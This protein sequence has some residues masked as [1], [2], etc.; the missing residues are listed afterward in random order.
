MSRRGG[1]SARGN[2]AAIEAATRQRQRAE[3]VA[4]IRIE[5]I[6]AG[7]DGVGRADGLACFVPRTAPGDVA[8]VA[9]QTHARHARGR[10]LQLL[11]ASPLRVEPTCRHYDGDRCGGCQLQHLNVDAQREARLTI[12]QDALRRIGKR[13]VPRATLVSGKEW[14]YRGRLTL[15]LK[16][17]GTT[18]IGGLHPYNDA[19][20]VFALEE[21]SIAH[22]SLVEAWHAVGAQLRGLPK[23]LKLRVALRRVALEGTT[24]VVSD[25]AVSGN[26]AIAIVIS[27]GTSWPEA[28]AWGIALHRSHSAI[29]AVWWE[30]ED[31]E[32]VAIVGGSEVDVDAAEWTAADVAADRDA[33]DVGPDATEALAFAQVNEEVAQALRAFVVE[34]VSAFTPAHAIDAYAGVGI[35][36]QLLA[37]AGVRITAIEADD[38]GVSQARRRLANAA[39]ARVICDTVENA[40]AATLPADVV[41]LNPPRRG[42]DIRVTALLADAAAN[43]VRAIVYVSC[44]PATLARDVARLASWRIAALRCFD[45]FPQTA[46]VETVCVLVPELT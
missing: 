19:S 1:R 6:A 21:C 8:Q 28:E 43:G 4:T 35:L 26:A 44:D 14:A 30:R 23:A 17:R 46:H 11:E 37:N 16:P 10:V 20:R 36:S 32:R 33:I 24:T 2:R 45:M 5:S 12:V 29:V 40:L 38:A 13:D 3:S 27:G 9:L 7:G 34:Q 42:V 22:P 39:G 15:T 31:G 25:G 18:W 41:V